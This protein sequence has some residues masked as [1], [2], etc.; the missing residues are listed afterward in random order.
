MILK[1]H[2]HLTKSFAI[3]KSSASFS[4]VFWILYYLLVKHPSFSSRK[5]PKN[6]PDSISCQYLSPNHLN[7]TFWENVWSTLLLKNS[8]ILV[9]ANSSSSQLSTRLLSKAWRREPSHWS[10]WELPRVGSRHGHALLTKFTWETSGS[11]LECPCQQAEGWALL[12]TR[13]SCLNM[14]TCLSMRNHSFENFV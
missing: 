11:H 5:S 14:R 13:S 10:S 3:T 2:I 9:A 12:R 6:S 4:H 1:C 8:S 7:V